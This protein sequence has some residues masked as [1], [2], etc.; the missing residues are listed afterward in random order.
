MKGLLDKDHIDLMKMLLGDPKIAEAV[1]V[2]IDKK[3]TYKDSYINEDG[4]IVLGKRGSCLRWWNKLFNLE[5][6]ISF[7]DFAFNTLAALVGLTEN[8]HR[9]TVLAGLSKD[10]V[11]KAVLDREYAYIVDQLFNVARFGAKTSLNPTGKIMK[12]VSP[13]LRKQIIEHD[14]HVIVNSGEGIPVYAHDGKRILNL[15]LGVTGYHFI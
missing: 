2:D 7:K 14:V 11:E 12:D 8:V 1:L 6:T 15:D 4:S 13:E 3:E 9:N 10:I 5:K